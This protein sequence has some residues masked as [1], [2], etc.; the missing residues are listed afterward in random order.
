MSN[1]VIPKG[2]FLSREQID[3]I[4]RTVAKGCDDNELALFLYTAKRLRLD[5]LARQIHAVKRWDSQAQRE[6]MAI[7]TGIDGYR[8][9]AERTGLYSGQDGPYWCGEDGVWHDVWL[10]SKP[11]SAAKVGI[12]RKGFDKPIWGIARFDAY[13]GRKKDGILT[14]M[15]STKGDIMIAKCAEALGLKK[16]F[17]HELSPLVTD[18]EM[19]SEPHGVRALA[20]STASAEPEETLWQ[21]A[22]ISDIQ[23]EKKQGKVVYAIQLE[24]GRI[25]RTLN[26]DLAE[27]TANVREKCTLIVKP[28]RKP[29]SWEYMGYKE[30][31]PAS[32]GGGEAQPELLE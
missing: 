8:L 6:V 22:K 11:P 17:P 2:E 28:G 19:E 4:K 7:Q 23:E 25:A 12:L 14:N 16:A 21:G 32:K 3:L 1:S 20:T 10:S 5:P 15:W 30:D 9:I 31:E 18:E 27:G 24:D 13:A 26:K 29:D